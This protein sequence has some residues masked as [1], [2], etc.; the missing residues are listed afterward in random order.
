MEIIQRLPEDV[1][2]NIIPYTYAVQSKELL[3]D[4]RSYYVTL[5]KAKDI[6]KRYWNVNKEDECN[7][8]GVPNEDIDWLINDIIGFMTLFKGKFNIFCQLLAIPDSNIALPK[9]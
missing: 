9:S 2:R 1:M 3:E 8:C 7:C 6:Y 5:K 4:I